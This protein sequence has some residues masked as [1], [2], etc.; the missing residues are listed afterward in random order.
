[1]KNSGSKMKKNL[2]HLF[3]LDQVDQHSAGCCRRSPRGDEAPVRSLRHVYN[4]KPPKYLKWKD[5]VLGN[6]PL[7]LSITYIRINWVSMQNWTR[8]SLKRVVP[9][10]NG[11]A[12][13]RTRECWSRP[14]SN[15]DQKLMVEYVDLLLPEIL[16]SPNGETKVGCWIFFWRGRRWCFFFFFN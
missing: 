12:R 2:P 8:Q 9:Q 10:T 3:L 11:A 4:L 13:T 6:R 7:G 14:V 16:P 5:D 15:V 1:M